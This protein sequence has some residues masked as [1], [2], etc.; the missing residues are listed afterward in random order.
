[1]RQCFTILWQ[2]DEVSALQ[3]LNTAGKWINAVPI[4]GALVVK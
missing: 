1:M 3:V 2:Q 4:P